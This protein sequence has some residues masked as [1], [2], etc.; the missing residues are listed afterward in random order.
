MLDVKDRIDDWREIEKTINEISKDEELE[1]KYKVMIFDSVNKI[2]FDGISNENE[3]IG[4]A[5]SNIKK[6]CERNKVLAFLNFELNKVRNDAK[7]S[8]YNLNGSRRMNYDANVLAFI[9]NP[10]RNLQQYEGTDKETKL[11]WSLELNGRVYKQPILFTIQEK[12]K[13]GNNEMNAQPYFY[14]L[15]TF[16]SELTPIYLNTEEYSYYYNQWR[17]EWDNLYRS[18]SSI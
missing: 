14:R 6:L 12:T 10:M 9:Y 11:N 3:A 18:Y 7:L 4:K 5:S 17:F 1:D 15:N 8:Q 16:T 13:N 2:S